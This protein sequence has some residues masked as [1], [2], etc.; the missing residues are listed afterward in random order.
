MP[1]MGEYRAVFEPSEAV[2][3][4]AG[5]S[6]LTRRSFEQSG[7]RNPAVEDLS[8]PAWHCHEKALQSTTVASGGCNTPDVRWPLH[9]GPLHA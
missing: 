9:P 4:V 5:T 1:G 2:G 6:T 7:E 8:H 3:H